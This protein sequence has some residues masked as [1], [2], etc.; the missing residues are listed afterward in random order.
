MIITA[1]F[2]LVLS[3]FDCVLTQ[4]S[5]FKLDRRRLAPPPPPCH[6]VSPP[7]KHHANM[8][9]GVSWTQTTERAGAREIARQPCCPLL[10]GRPPLDHHRI[11]PRP[12]P[13]PSPRPWIPTATS[14]EASRNDGGQRWRAEDTGRVGAAK[15]PFPRLSLR[16][17]RHLLPALRPH[18]HG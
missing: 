15:C 13:G 7:S 12:T 9:G 4:Y 3:H 10:P 2:S 1:R 8:P 5:F 16:H 11:R 18:P 17:L 6:H 14:P